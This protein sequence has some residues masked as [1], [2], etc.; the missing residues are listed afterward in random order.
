MAEVC[1]KIIIIIIIILC[2]N[3]LMTPGIVKKE[4][5]RTFHIDNNNDALSKQTRDIDLV[6]VW[7]WSTVYDAGQTL[8]RCLVFAGYS[9]KT[10]RLTCLCMLSLVARITKS[11]HNLLNGEGHGIMGR[12]WRF[13]SP[14]PS[15]KTKSCICLL[16]KKSKQILPFWLCTA[17]LPPLVQLVQETS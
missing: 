7:C 10:G 9:V 3:I 17:E 14:L 2:I 8:V 15:P 13:P 11:Q 6:V 16:E 1:R 4:L 12:T 5:H